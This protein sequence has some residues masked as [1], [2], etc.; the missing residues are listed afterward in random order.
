MRIILTIKSILNY[1]YNNLI[2]LV[3]TKKIKFED[4]TELTTVPTSFDLLDIKTLSEKITNKGWSCISYDTQH[5]LNKAD[6]PTAYNFLKD[7]LD[8]V[9]ATLSNWSTITYNGGYFQGAIFGDYV[10]IIN[11]GIYKCLKSELNDKTKW[12]EIAS[13]SNWFDLKAFTIYEDKIYIGIDNGSKIIYIIDK[14]TLTLI[15]MFYAVNDFWN[16][17]FSICD[18]YVYYSLSATTYRF[19]VTSNPDD[20]VVEV[21]ANTRIVNVFR[22]SNGYYFFELWN[23]NYNEAEV[24]KATDLS[25]SSTYVKLF[26]DWN[27]DGL[28]NLNDG[29]F[30]KWSAD[31]SGFYLY[32]CDDLENWHTN[33]GGYN[34]YCPFVSY[35]TI[36]FT[37]L[38]IAGSYQQVNQIFVNNTGWSLV[39]K[40]SGVYYGVYTKDFAGYTVC[41]LDNSYSQYISPQFECDGNYA[42]YQVQ[43]ADSTVY[44]TI[45]GATL[46]IYTDT[47]IINGSSV[48]IKYYKN[49][50][51]KICTPDIAVGNDTNLQ[52]VYEYL[53]YLN[54][55]WIDTTN[56][57]I[58]LQRNSN[59][60]TFQYVGDDYEDDVLPNG[61][62]TRLLPQAELIE[63]DTASVTLDIL[64]NKVYKFTNSA[65]TDITFSTV[66]DSDVP[67][68]IKF[69]TGNSAPTF[70]DNSGIN[71]VDGTPV[72]QANYTYQIIIF[73]KDGYIKEF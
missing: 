30:Y 69:T 38:G 47:Y 72:F 14:N 61:N 58:T 10:L 1:L 66:E 54:Y 50:D 31:S 6:V 20:I 18:G 26:T 45:S 55:W 65:I 29:N 33:S 32:K 9:D 40:F 43:S 59:L 8:N 25:D 21:V 48:D 15:K 34:D 49:G 24:W 67:T 35:A 37:D 46:T 39:F 7:K 51:M 63:I 19:P 62:A 57:K 2:D 71:W 4:G 53:G 13:G 64:K 70:T 73:G 68:S 28:I 22:K 41:Q 27:H 36:N 56:E 16:S 12:V 42:F 17:G 3:W 23:G 52:S 60:W 11:R 44:A 5:K